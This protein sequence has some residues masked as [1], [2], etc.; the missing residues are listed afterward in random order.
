ME[1]EIAERFVTK[2]LSLCELIKDLLENAKA[3]KIDVPVDPFVMSLVIN[4]I[5]KEREGDPC[6]VVQTFILRSFD[7]WDRAAAREK[8]YFLTTGI[9]AFT[10]AGIPE[11]NADSFKELFNVKKQDG[12]LLIDESVQGQ[13]WDIFESLIK[14]SVVYIHHARQPDRETKKYTKSFFPSLS[15]KKEIERWKIESLE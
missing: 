12:N 14:T 7:S 1:T 8:D 13:I 2:V 15:V 9:S 10:G 6:K 11:K 4:F 5:K 3:D